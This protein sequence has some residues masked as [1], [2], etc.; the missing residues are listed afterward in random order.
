MHCRNVITLSLTLG[1]S[2]MKKYHYHSAAYKKSLKGA[3]TV[4]RE[5]YRQQKYTGHA[6]FARQPKKIPERDVKPVL[7]YILR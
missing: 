6:R 4:R 5:I 2:F 3:K 7:T 1:I